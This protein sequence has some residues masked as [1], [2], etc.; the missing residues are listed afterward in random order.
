M[1]PEQAFINATKFRGRAYYYF[2]DEMAKAFGEDRA[3]EVYSKAIYRLGIDKSNSFKKE[4]G[5]SAMALADDFV[6]NE[7]GR[8]VFA[9]TILSAD[10]NEATIEMKNCPLVEAWKEMNLTD[11]MI[12]RL[13]DLAY[14][15]DYG[16]V[17]GLGFKL[18]FKSR[19][20]DGCPACI[21][22]IHK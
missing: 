10:E 2:Y 6:G 17:E 21:L 13:C 3:A 20:S 7:T 14:Q 8:N 1:T 4:S 19:I 12:S 9:Q 5:K 11:E 15:V 16:T 18:D 22:H